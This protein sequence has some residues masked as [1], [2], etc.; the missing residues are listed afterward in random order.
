MHND[1]G[2]KRSDRGDNEV[3]RKEGVGTGG[4][5]VRGGG[6]AANGNPTAVPDSLGADDSIIGVNGTA[7]TEEQTIGED[8]ADLSIMNAEDPGLGITNVG[9]RGPDDWAADTGPTRTNEGGTGVATADLSDDGSTL[10]PDRSHHRNVTA[11][12]DIKDKPKRTK[13][14]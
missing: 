11:R 7:G 2:I 6:S 12:E 3:R 4:S 14:R 13:K 8:L 1:G 5:G 9:D 10:G